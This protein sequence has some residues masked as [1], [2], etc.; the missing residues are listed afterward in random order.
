MVRHWPI[1]RA[2]LIWLL[3]NFAPGS[4]LLQHYLQ[5][6]LGANDAQWG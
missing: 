3:W 2:F 4:A 6:T 1:H 5:N